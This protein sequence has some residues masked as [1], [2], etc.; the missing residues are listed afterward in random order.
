MQRLFPRVYYGW[1]MVGASLVIN[2]SVSPLNAV[3]F[4]FLIGPI[5][6][7]LNVQKSALAWSLTLRLI[8]AGLSGPLIGVLL[9]RYGS[10]W[11][12]AICGAIGGVSLIALGAAHSLWV[13]YALFALSGLAGFGGPA[14]QLLTQVPLAK[15]F[16]ANRGRAIAIATMGMALGTVFTVPAT[17]WLIGAIGWRGATVVFGIA[18]AGLVVPVSTLFMRRSPDDMGLHPDGAESAQAVADAAGAQ[19]RAALLSTTRDWTVREALYTPAMWLM[20]VALTLQGVVLMGTLVYRVDFWQSKGMAPSLVGLGTALDPLCV[21]FSILVFGMIA[22]R[23]PIRYLGF[24]GVAGMALSMVPM[25]V[26]DGQTWTILAH[27]SIWGIS[28]GGWITLNSLL[29]PNY[30][31]RLH[32]GAIRGIVLPVSI[33]AS[34]AGAPLFGYLLDSGMEPARLWTIG[35]I[36]FAISA[37]FVLLARPPRAPGEPPPHSASASLRRAAV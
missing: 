28:A 31:G 29:W 34:S 7:D 20:L 4:S 36:G 17:Q 32:L 18:V 27:N 13:V 11:L 9:D 24:I 21:V 16:V 8:T 15:W 22:D 30:F 26:S 33:A 37:V 25:V 35:L 5:S 12:G 23:M 3:V 19:T 2:M 1:V 10:R 14:G 6:A